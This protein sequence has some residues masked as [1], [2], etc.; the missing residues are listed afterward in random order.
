MCLLAEEPSFKGAVLGETPRIRYNNKR[1]EVRSSRRSEN[2]L[3]DS[4]Q[5]SIPKNLDS[6]DI[7]IT[8]V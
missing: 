5:V 6:P 3:C 7:S 1:S 4:M 8:T 2:V